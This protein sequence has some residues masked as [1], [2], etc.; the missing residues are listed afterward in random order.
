[1]TPFATLS[2]EAQ[3]IVNNFIAASRA[4][5]FLTEAHKQIM[6]SLYGEMPNADKEVLDVLSHYQI[7]LDDYFSKS[8]I[9]TLTEE[10]S[11]V[12]NYCYKYNI[13]SIN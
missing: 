12:I 3:N 6:V 9:Q 10:Y 1:M 4:K 13:T 2:T 11:A 7:H 8:E 5:S